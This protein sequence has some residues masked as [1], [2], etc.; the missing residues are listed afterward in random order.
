MKKIVTI[1]F[2]SLIATVSFGQKNW[3]SWKESNIQGIDFRV[4]YDYYNEY[5]AKQGKPAHVWCMEIRNRY[6]S[7]KGVS[8]CLG[9]YGKA[10]DEIKDQRRN[11]CMKPG[12]IETSCIHFTNTP[13]GGTVSVYI[14]KLEDCTW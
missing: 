7:K 8:W 9:D 1:F 13:K 12:E 2:Y 4:A 3:S 14:W 10:K 6:Q 11:S 5:S